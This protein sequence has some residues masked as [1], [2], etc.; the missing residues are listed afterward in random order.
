MEFFPIL[1]KL[2]IMASFNKKLNLFDKS[3]S[4]SSSQHQ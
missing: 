1:N 3:M 2:I 4:D